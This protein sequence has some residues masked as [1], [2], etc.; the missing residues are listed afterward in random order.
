MEPKAVYGPKKLYISLYGKHLCSI[1]YFKTLALV[2]IA[3]NLH[4]FIK[5]KKKPASIYMR[6]KLMVVQMAKCKHKLLF[7]EKKTVY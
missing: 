5:Q 1:L 3:K 4:T 6:K 2:Y 7:L